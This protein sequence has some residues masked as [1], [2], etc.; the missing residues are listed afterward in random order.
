MSVMSATEAEAILNA[1][2]VRAFSALIEHIMDTTVIPPWC[3]EDEQYKLHVINLLCEG[4]AES[5]LGDLAKYEVLDP[6]DPASFLESGTKVYSE[7]H[8]E[9]FTVLCQLNREVVAVE[10]LPGQVLKRDSLVIVDV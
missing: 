2:S 3:D 10:E 4:K 9:T 7:A 8:G 1:L 5:I 6:K